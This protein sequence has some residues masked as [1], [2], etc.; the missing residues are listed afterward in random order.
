MDALTRLHGTKYRF[1]NI[2]KVIYPASG[3]LTD[4]VYDSAGIKYSFAAEL[5][6]TGKFGFL[7]PTDQ[8]IPTCQEFWAAIKALVGEISKET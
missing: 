7:L 6:D 3:S 2:A 8:I 1:G 4:W 5:R